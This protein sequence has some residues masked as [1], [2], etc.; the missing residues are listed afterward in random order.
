MSSGHGRGGRKISDEEQA[1][2]HSALKDVRPLR[3][4]AH[5]PV[6]ETPVKA[7][8][9]RPHF[10]RAPTHGGEPAPFIE[11]H[12]EVHLRRGRHEPEARLDL[13]G[14]SHDI[15]YGAAVRFL[16]RAQSEGKR[17]VLIITGKGG[18]LRARLP[19]WL[20]QP[21]LESLIAGLREAH[22]RHGGAGAFYVLLRRH[23]W[24]HMRQDE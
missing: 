16:Y 24:Q 5:R 8:T 21:E 1:L 17:L 15:A 6:R 22:I 23:E 14:M 18:V 2:F 12:Q 7:P 3:K 10:P 19:F 9:S 13:H 4:K 20:G 11:G